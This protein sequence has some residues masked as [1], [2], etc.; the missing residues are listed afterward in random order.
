VLFSVLI[1]LIWAPLFHIGRFIL[2]FDVLCGLLIVRTALVVT[3]R[4]G[5]VL[6]SVLA[7]AHF[8]VAKVGNWGGGKKTL[9]G[10]IR[11]GDAPRIRNEALI[12]YATEPNTWPPI[13][14]KQR[15]DI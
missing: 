2:V 8:G 14:E 15:T 12:F 5:L 7:L 11:V 13:L 10:T 6:A 4:I 3:G 9:D 1:Y